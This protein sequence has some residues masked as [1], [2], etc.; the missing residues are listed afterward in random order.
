METRRVTD[1]A[2]P[3]GVVIAGSVI[4]GQVLSPAGFTFELSAEGRGFWR[5]LRHRPVHEGQSVPGVSF[6]SYSRAC[7]LRMGRRNDPSCRLPAGPR[8]DRRT[9]I[10]AVMNALGAL[11]LEGALRNSPNCIAA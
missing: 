6:P 2:G 9:A 5:C 1:M 7:R 4:P 3:A 11:R 10:A 8:S